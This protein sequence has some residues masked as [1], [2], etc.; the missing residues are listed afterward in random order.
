MPVG[1]IVS[2][3]FGTVPGS[4]AQIG[5]VPPTAQTPNW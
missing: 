2:I 4:T 3:T 1:V 5:D